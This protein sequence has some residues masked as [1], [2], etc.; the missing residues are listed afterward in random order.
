MALEIHAK[1]FDSSFELVQMIRNLEIEV[2]NI[3]W[4]LRDGEF[5]NGYILGRFEGSS[6]KIKIIK[7]SEAYEFEFYEREELKD[8]LVSELTAAILDKVGAS[9]IEDIE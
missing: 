6:N 3:A 1:K 9:N 2:I 4:S 5:N 7:T 8:G